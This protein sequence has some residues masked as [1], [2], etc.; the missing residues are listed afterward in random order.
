MWGFIKASLLV[1][2]FSY[3][4]LFNAPPD[5]IFNIDIHTDDATFDITVMKAPDLWQQLELPCELIWP[6]RHYRLQ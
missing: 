5:I 6:K 1:K 3:Y 4:T 2:H